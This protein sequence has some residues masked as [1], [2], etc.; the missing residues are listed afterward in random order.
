MEPLRL[1]LLWVFLPLLPL[2][3]PAA[4]PPVPP[5]PSLGV[6]PQKLQYL[7]GDTVFLH[8]A[9]PP[10]TPQVQGFQFLG[11]GGWALEVRTRQRSHVQ[12]FDIRGPGDGGRLS[13]TYTVPHPD[14]SRRP[15]RSQESPGVFISIRDRPPAPTLTLTPGGGVTIEGQT[16]LFLCAAPAEVLPRCF[17]FFKEKEEV[18]DE[19]NEVNEV[20]V[21]RGVATA[22]LPLVATGHNI[23]G[24]FSCG[25]EEEVEGRRILSHLSPHLQVVVKEPPLPP[26]LG[27]D[28]PGGV[29]GEGHPLR[30]TCKAT[31]EDFPLRFHFSR[32]GTELQGWKPQN[33]G[34]LAQIF[35]PQTPTSLEGTWRC[36]VEEDMGGMWVTSP[37]S[38]PLEVTIKAT[39][40]QPALLLDPP[41]AEVPPDAPLL[42][43]CM[44]Q[45]ST[46]LRNFS[47]YQDGAQL[48]SVTTSR[49]RATFTLPVVANATPATGFIF[50]CRY[51]EKINDWWISSPF[52]QP[53]T[54]TTR[55]PS[56]FIPLVV[57]CVAGGATLFVVGL[58]LAIWLCRRRR[59]RVHWSG[60][61][62]RDDPSTI[63]MANVGPC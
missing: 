53:V 36:H 52:S 33:L 8:C 41:T 47:F 60:L 38:E 1:L 3:V 7:I 37:P 5:A 10:S 25:Y 27:V 42:L 49:D 16:L 44:A 48:F 6:T 51:H 50:S 63:P 19:V 28:P 2:L 35:I 4:L 40:S 58:L 39:P 24:N 20:K 12:T 62:N 45:G 61:R 13:C 17:R 11:A 57:S 59:G 54:V 55:V 34:I 15:L 56:Q 21:I 31:R 14:G 32:N 18:K 22:H 30:V 23:T 9:A 46:T 29:V 26:T 43:T